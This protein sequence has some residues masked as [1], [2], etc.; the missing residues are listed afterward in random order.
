MSKEQSSCYTYFMIRGDFN[1]DSISKMLDLSPEQTWK[2]GD[3]RKNGTIYDFS[4]WK[5]GT[6]DEYDVYVENQML[7]TITPLISKISILKEIK[8]QYDVSFTL[9]IVPTIISDETTPC[10]APSLEIMQFC[11]D[12]GTEMDIDLYV[13]IVDK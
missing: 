12:T 8:K 2:I 1:P 10:L 4:C 6:C 3:K 9:E 13:D 11:C 5:F 7:K